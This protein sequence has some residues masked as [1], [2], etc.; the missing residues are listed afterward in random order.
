MT[1]SARTTQ[2]GNAISG[3]NETDAVGGDVIASETGNGSAD[4]GKGTGGE[5]E[6]NGGFADSGDAKVVNV[7]FVKQESEQEMK[8]VGQRQVVVLQLQEEAP[9]LTRR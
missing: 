4:G 6:A 2:T 8:V 1:R 7:A 9:Q 3:G 5:A